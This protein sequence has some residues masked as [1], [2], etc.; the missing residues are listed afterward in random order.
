LTDKAARERE[1]IEI[2]EDWDWSDGSC[3]IGGYAVSAY[4]RPRYSRDLD[5]VIPT[6][7]SEDVLGHLGEL[8]FAVR[9]I[10]KP[11]RPDAFRD[12]LRLERGPLAIDLMIG[13]VRD[14]DTGASVSW[15]WIT[16]G[17]RKMRLILLTGSTRNLVTVVRPEVLWTLKVI[18][19]R[20]QDLGDLFAISSEAI[21]VEEI[22]EFLAK[23]DTP[24]LREKV[25][26]ESLRLGSDRILME[27]M[28]ARFLPSSSD[29]AKK[30][31]ARFL[32][33]FAAA[34]SWS[35]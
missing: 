9:A 25:K 28:S 7:S 12:S 16:N 19:G 5:F 23:M 21:N 20:N 34:T 14:R 27:S 6:A 30:S 32:R 13:Y 22:R 29:N 26:D 8:G 33:L 18:A 17:A 2:L 10:R 11:D 15:Q 1:A 31:W 35:S 4:G 24:A 3:I